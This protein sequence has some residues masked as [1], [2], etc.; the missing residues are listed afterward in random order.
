MR[1]IFLIFL[2]SSILS[3]CSHDKDLHFVAGTATYNYVAN[4]SNSPLKGCAAALASGL[5]K[6]IYDSQFGGIVDRYDAFATGAGCMYT[7]RF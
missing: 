7:I 5:A 1:P 6:E 2:S 4:H 3:G